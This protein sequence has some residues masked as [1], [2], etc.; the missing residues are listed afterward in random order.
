MSS[1]ALII[2]RIGGSFLGRVKQWGGIFFFMGEALVFLLH[3]E[4]L[5]RAT[6]SVI[7]KQI[8]F[9]AV[10]VLPVFLLFSG[11]LSLVLIHIIVTTARDFGL[12]GYAPGLILDVL[13]REL[14]PLL[15]AFFI[16]LRSGAAINTEVALMKIN[17][18]LEALDACGVEPMRFELA[19][20]IV[21]GIVSVLALTCMASAVALVLGYLV[22]NGWQWR[23][24]AG[25]NHTLARV[26]TLPVVLGLWFKCII[27]GIVVTAIPISAGLDAPKKLFF[28]PIAVLRG[29]VRV[30]FAIMIIEVLTLSA[31]Y[32]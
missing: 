31:K 1:P 29:M 16:A 30:F 11:V 9:T 7:V 15:A 23:D 21:A 4:S 12:F 17:N 5:N 18:E 32:I 22:S 26:M 13:I 2:T 28:A 10:Q 25:F 3:R 27:F 14:L 6:L 8:Y 19:P 20:R 24:L